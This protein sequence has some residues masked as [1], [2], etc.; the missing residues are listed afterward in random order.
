MTLTTKFTLRILEKMI[1]GLP[2]NEATADELKEIIARSG[3]LHEIAVQRLALF[4]PPLED[5][6]LSHTEVLFTA[7]R[8]TVLDFQQELMDTT[9]P[10]FRFE[11]GATVVGRPINQEAVLFKEK[12]EKPIDL[13]SGWYW[14]NELFLRAVADRLQVAH[15]IYP[16]DAHL[17]EKNSW[18]AAIRIEPPFSYAD[19]V[20]ALAGEAHTLEGPSLATRFD[21]IRCKANGDGSFDFWM[22]VC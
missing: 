12:P 19:V 13:E 2:G 17:D 18:I 3:A 16:T 4:P 6:P 1:S 20:G 11:S 15:D 21:H 10:M 5:I 9:P 7:A 22:R 14:N 8:R